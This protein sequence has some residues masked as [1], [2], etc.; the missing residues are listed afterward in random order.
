MDPHYFQKLIAILMDKLINN[1]M[2]KVPEH[3][4]KEGVNRIISD[5]VKK[6]L[7]GHKTTQKKFPI[8]QK[9]K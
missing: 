6:Q 9:R 8:R 7:F 4:T 3:T 2:T 5:D 1:Y